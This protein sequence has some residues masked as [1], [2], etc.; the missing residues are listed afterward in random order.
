MGYQ[1]QQS[2]HGFRHVASSRLNQMRHMSIFN[3]D[4]IELQQD[5]VIHGTQN[6]KI[7]YEFEP[8]IQIETRTVMMQFWSDY[9]EKLPRE[10]DSTV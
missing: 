6:R 2:V 10:F 8:L 5:R 1:G 4:D 7:Y 9:V 3:D